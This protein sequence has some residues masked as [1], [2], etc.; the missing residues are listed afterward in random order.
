MTPEASVAL[1]AAQRKAVREYTTVVLPISE[2]QI[3]LQRFVKSPSPDARKQMRDAVQSFEEL[4]GKPDTKRIVDEWWGLSDEV[5]A[6]ILDDM[7]SICS[8]ARKALKGMPAEKADKGAK[9]KIAPAKPAARKMARR[10][11]K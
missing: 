11:K 8:D 4:L 7:R 3:T 2:L 10:F 1:S 5:D 9:K 6:S